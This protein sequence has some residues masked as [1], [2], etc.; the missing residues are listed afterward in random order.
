MQI[1]FQKVL[2]GDEAHALELELGEGFEEIVWDGC[3]GV[4]DDDFCLAF[5]KDVFYLFYYL[6]R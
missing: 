6:L 2:D 3:T 5:V 4:E 1:V